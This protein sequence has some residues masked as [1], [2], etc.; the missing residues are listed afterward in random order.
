VVQL[1][2]RLCLLNESQAKLR[3][4]SKMAMH[5]LDSNLAFKVAVKRPKNSSH[6]PIT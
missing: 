2:R 3:L 1:R 4:S 6:A 5:Q